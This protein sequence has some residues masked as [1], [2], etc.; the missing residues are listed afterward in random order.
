MNP[1]VE[2]RWQ[3]AKLR[4]TAALGDSVNISCQI[5]GLETTDLNMGMHWLQSSIY[6][7]F[8]VDFH[9]KQNQETTEVIFSTSEPDYE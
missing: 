2:K 9:V 6:E 4:L 1:V 3:D 5:P 8:V 7:G